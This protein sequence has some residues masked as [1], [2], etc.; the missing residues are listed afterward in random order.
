MKKRV[1]SFRF[2]SNDENRRCKTEEEIEKGDRK[3]RQHGNTKISWVNGKR[4]K[5]GWKYVSYHDVIIAR[6]S[7]LSSSFQLYFLHAF[8]NGESTWNFRNFMA[9]W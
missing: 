8:L 1:S 5:Y 7:I 9:I 3:D 2:W 4:K 6:I